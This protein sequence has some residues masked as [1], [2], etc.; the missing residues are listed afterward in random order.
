VV[1]NGT[2]K[3]NLRSILETFK[4]PL[5]INLDIVVLEPTHSL[6]P[7]H[8]PTIASS[9][10][11]GSPLCT[12]APWFNYPRTQGFCDFRSSFSALYP[13]PL[14]SV[15][16]VRLQY[17]RCRVYRLPLARTH[18]STLRSI[19]TITRLSPAICSSC[20]VLF[21]HSIRLQIAQHSEESRL[22]TRT[23]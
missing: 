8:P 22:S 6:Q 9:H 5:P 12:C 1:P 13:H 17:P 7:F 3:K 2:K 18:H 10:R 21:F 14:G 4:F 20:V 16:C 11:S 15:H 23:S 19:D